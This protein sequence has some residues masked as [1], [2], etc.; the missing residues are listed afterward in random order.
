M[1]VRP[2]RVLLAFVNKS[3]DDKELLEKLRT[4]LK[5]T[6]NDWN[7]ILPEDFEKQRKK[8]DFFI[9]DIRRPEDYAKGHI[10]GAKNIFWLD[11]L[12]D[13]NLK[14]LPK[15]KKIMIYCYVGHTSSQALVLLKLLGYDVIALKFG[16]GKSPTEGVPVAGWLDY[17]YELKR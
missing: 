9:L 12:D 3:A 5:D 15:D 14:K 10:P 7:Y 17:G 1:P 8:K 6:R 11:L 4:F 16:L 13:E 2:S